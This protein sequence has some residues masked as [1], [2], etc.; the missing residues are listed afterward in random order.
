MFIYST[1]VYHV[2]SG[3]SMPQWLSE[4]KKKA[5]RKN[6]DFRRRMELLQDF[7]FPSACQHIKVTP[8]EQYIFATGYHPPILKVYD[9]NNLSLKFDRHLDAEVVDFQVRGGSGICSSVHDLGD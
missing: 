7:Q 5:L 2:T 8:D 3:K 9:L 6:E 4:N 1:Q